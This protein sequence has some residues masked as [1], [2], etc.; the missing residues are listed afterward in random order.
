MPQM[1]V[2]GLLTE[3]LAVRVREAVACMLW[4]RTHKADHCVVL[5]HWYTCAKSWV[6][7]LAGSHTYIF[8]CANL[9][10]LLSV[11]P[12]GHHAARQ[13]LITHKLS[14]DTPCT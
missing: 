14:H 4:A 7:E 13:T 12:R 3:R 2:Q 1:L 9:C 10:S 8:V 5:Q 6:H 11:P